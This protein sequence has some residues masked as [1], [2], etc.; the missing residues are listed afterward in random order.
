MNHYFLSYRVHRHTHTDR[1]TDR[2]TDRHEYS[3][4]AVINRNYNKTVQD[5]NFVKRSSAFHHVLVFI[6]K[7]R[8]VLFIDIVEYTVWIEIACVKIYFPCL[9]RPSL[10]LQSV[11]LTILCLDI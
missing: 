10:V 9:Q 7:K 2:Q 11:G 8:C 5:S 4:V 6:V 3:I 1:N